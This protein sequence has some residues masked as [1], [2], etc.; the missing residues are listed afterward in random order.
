MISLAR[1]SA[2]APIPPRGSGSLSGGLAQRGL[3]RMQTR[4]LLLQ[5]PF[6]YS[7]TPRGLVQNLPPKPKPL[8]RLKRVRPSNQWNQEVLL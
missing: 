1:S 5:W 8:K 7:V 3:A 4:R 2:G 6:L